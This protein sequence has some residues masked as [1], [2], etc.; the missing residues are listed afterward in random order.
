MSN[1]IDAIEAHYQ[2]RTVGAHEF[3][4]EFVDRKTELTFDSEASTVFTKV[5]REALK[6]AFENA[7]KHFHTAR[8]Y[9]DELIDK[10]DNQ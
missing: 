1:T 3:F 4:T 8:I 2:I 10:L 7:K 6:I 9:S 5:D